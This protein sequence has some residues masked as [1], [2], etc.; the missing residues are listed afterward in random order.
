[1][2]N[3]NYR[4]LTAPYS[5]NQICRLLVPAALMVG[6]FMLAQLLTADH[7]VG[8]LAGLVAM[9]AFF[10]VTMQ[11]VKMFCIAVVRGKNHRSLKKAG[12]LDRALDSMGQM[13]T[14]QADHFRFGM[15]DE[16]LVLP[17]GGILRMDQIAWFFLQENKVRYFGIPISNSKSGM[18]RTLD[19]GSTIAFY[20]K[21]RDI[22]AFQKMLLE[23][24]LRV[25]QMLIGHTA[26]N[27][28]AYNAMVQANKV[29]SFQN[30]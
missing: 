9:A 17:Y 22:A 7:A 11:C 6:G 4:Q 26:Q 27:V 8:L 25:P 5:T 21:P 1:M 28:Q 19:G 16:F 20:G 23:L 12:L 3:E 15:N 2:K 14:F 24:K 30:R 29:S 10:I 13:E 18:I